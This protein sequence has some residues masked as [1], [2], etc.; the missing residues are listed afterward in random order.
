MKGKF[1]YFISV[2]ECALCGREDVGRERRNTP[3]PEKWEDRH[4]F[5]QYACSE[6]FV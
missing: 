4:E 1:W 2:G 6:H 5:W 3:R